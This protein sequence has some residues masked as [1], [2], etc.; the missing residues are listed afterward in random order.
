MFIVEDDATFGYRTCTLVDAILRQN[1]DLDW[2]ILF[3]DVCITNLKKMIDLLQYR[4][5]LTAKKIDIAFMG[6]NK[7]G[8]AGS[9][10]YIVNAN[11]KKKLYDLLDAAAAIDQPY[12]L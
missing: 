3:T 1:K 2:D 10:P 7:V 5:D 11:S 9:T 6:I 12:D 8:F 4:R